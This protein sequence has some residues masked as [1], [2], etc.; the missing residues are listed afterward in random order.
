M[1]KEF[2]RQTAIRTDRTILATFNPSNSGS[3]V[4]DLESREDSNFIHSTFRDNTFLS[5]S[6]VAELEHFA[7]T[8]ANFR[9]VYLNGEWGNK[10]GLIFTNWKIGKFQGP[11][12]VI[13]LDLAFTKDYTSAVMVQPDGRDIYCKQIIHQVGIKSGAIGKVLK[14]FRKR[15]IADS[16]H[17][18]MISDI[19]DNGVIIEGVRKYSGFVIDRINHAQNFNLIIDPSSKDLIKALGIYSWQERNGSYVDKP[20]HSYSDAV[21]AM[22]YAMTEVGFRQG[23]ARVRGVA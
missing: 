8:D 10:E 17:Q 14:P 20:N 1:P 22:M 19:S 12:K 18:S 5:P 11:G 16:S 6:I 13:G 7:A 23:T 21:D 2:Y 3:W 9:D 4:R 15:V